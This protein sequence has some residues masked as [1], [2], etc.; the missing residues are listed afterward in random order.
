VDSDKVPTVGFGVE[1]P[2]LVGKTANEATE[3]ATEEGIASIRV[4]ESVDGVT[5]TPMNTDWS[6]TRLNLI[7][8]GGVVVKARFG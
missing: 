3:L 4:L 1:P 2:Y 7:V 5:I 8:E 6:P